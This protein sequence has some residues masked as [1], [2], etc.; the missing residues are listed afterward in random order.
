MITLTIEE[1]KD[2]CTCQQLYEKKYVLNEKPNRDREQAHFDGHSYIVL[3][4]QRAIKELTGFYFH[5]LMDN[6]QIRFETLYRKWEKKW[7]KD[8]TGMDIAEYIVP[9]NRANRVR[10]NTNFIR[11]LPKFHKTFHK[12]FKPIAVDKEVLF[13]LNDIVLTSKI[14]MAYRLPSGKI[15][16]VKFIPNKIAPGPPDKDLDLV[17]Q[18]CSWLFIYDEPS[19]EISYYCM[20]SPDEYN[21]FTVSSIDRSMIPKLTRIVKAFQDNETLGVGVCSGCEYDCEDK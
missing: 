9:V 10:I 12:P 3:E 14:E 20:F 11:H 19:V 16:I 8:F 7:W 1:L 13:P 21:P 17:V 5:R 4:A 18:A 2:Y 6:R 15:R